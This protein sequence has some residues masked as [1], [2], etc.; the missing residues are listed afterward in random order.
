MNGR[1]LAGGEPATAHLLEVRRDN[2]FRPG[3]CPPW[4]QRQQPSDYRVSGPGVQ[5]LVGNRPHQRF[6]RIASGMGLMQ[7]R[8]DH[9][10]VLTPVII[11]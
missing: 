3:E 5:L 9:G 11:E 1:D 6:I 4:K 2:L 10:D 7:A 8:A